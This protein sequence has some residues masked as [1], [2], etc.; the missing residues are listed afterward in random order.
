MGD[1]STAYPKDCCALQAADLF[2]YEI[3]K[4]YE[5]LLKKPDGEMRWALKRILA[6][7]GARPLIQLYDSHEM[8]RIYL[9]ATGQDQHA[10]AIVA[11]LLTDSWLRKIA[12]R[13]VLL[14]R[15]RS[16]S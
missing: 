16:A 5:N 11:G 7:G 13:D 9:E 3:V 6:Q 14:S 1:F 2:S 4:E 15:L 12:V 10:D 8:L